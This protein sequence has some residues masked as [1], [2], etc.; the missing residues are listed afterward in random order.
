[1]RVLI[2]GA[3]GVTSRAVARAL[4]T[5][6]RL[7]DLW[8][9]GTDICDNP[10]GLYEGL[11]DRVYRAPRVSAH[12]Y[13]NWM[14]NLCRDEKVDAAIVIPE[15]EVLHWSAAGFPVPALLPPPAFCRI[16]VSKRRLYEALIGHGLVPRFH[17]GSREAILA[18]AMPADL[19]YPCWIRDFSEGGSSGKGALLAHDAGELHA[20]AVLNRGIDAFMLSDYLPGRNF[21]CHLLYDQGAIVKIACYERLE[22]FM[23]RTAASGVTGNISR[24]RLL[25]D[26]RLVAAAHAAVSAILGQTGETMDGLVAVDLREAQ[27]GRPLVTEINLRHVAA[28]SAFAAAGFNLAESHL[29]LTL[30]RRGELGPLEMR[31]PEGNLILR[32]I[33]G[34]PLWVADY[35]ELA[36]GEFA[37][38]R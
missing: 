17:I 28:T 8:L 33:D 6:A 27:D 1:M 18:G 26:E 34:Q 2:T 19:A 32:D 13:A 3:C 38:R 20:W 5:S 30:G 35:R 31:F 22:Y 4:R 11:Y 29:L 10:Y 37:P 7:P 15:L 14:A 24:G 36:I 9:L 21:A 12:G 23:A 16:A 25:N